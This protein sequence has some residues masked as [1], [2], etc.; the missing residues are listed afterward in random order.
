MNICITLKQ[1]AEKIIANR[2]LTLK[3]NIT[4][5]VAPGKHCPSSTVQLNNTANIFIKGLSDNGNKPEIS[6][7]QKSCFSLRISTL[8][9]IE[10]LLFAHSFSEVSNGGTI[11]VSGAEFVIIFQCAF[12]NNTI[13]KQGGAMRLQHIE[14]AY[15]LETQFINN[16]V[17]CRQTV[18]AGQL[19][20]HCIQRCTAFGGAVSIAYIKLLLIADSYFERN[21]AT[22][23][24]GMLVSVNSHI[25]LH[26]CT[27]IKSSTIDAPGLGGCLYIDVSSL[28]VVDSVFSENRGYFGGGIYSTSSMVDI[29]N[30][31]FLFN[32]ANLTGGG[33]HFDTYLTNSISNSYFKNNFAN[34]GGAAFIIHGDTFISRSTF[35]SNIGESKGGALYIDLHGQPSCT[36]S[37]DNKVIP[38]GNESVVSIVDSTFKQNKQKLMGGAIFAFRGV[39]NIT[40]CDFVENTGSNGGA[41]NANIIFL[42]IQ[43]NNFT[44]NT[45]GL[46]GAGLYFGN[47][48][49]YSSNN[50][51]KTNTGISGGALYSIF[52]TAVSQNDR[53]IAN[54]AYR[55]NG[56]AIHSFYADI[57]TTYCEFV[58]NYALLGGG[59]LFVG[60]GRYN[61]RKSLY[62]TNYSNRNGSALYISTS[63]V[64]MNGDTFL[65]NIG[66]QISSNSQAIFQLHNN[67]LNDDYSFTI[68]MTD[69]H[70]MCTNSTFINNVGS[71]YL[72]FSTLNFTSLLISV[73][74][75]GTTGGALTLVQSTAIFEHSS[76]VN[77][78]ENTALYGGGIFLSQSDLR[79]YTQCLNV[80]N[81]SA[82]K[83][84]GGIYG[85]Q[86]QITVRPI[87]TTDLTLFS[88]NNASLGGALFTVATS[89]FIFHGSTTF[90]SNHALRGGAAVLSEGSKIY[91]QKSAQDIYN[92]L[93][94]KLLFSNNSADYGGAIYVM[95]D[96]NSAV[97]CQQTARSNLRTLS[98]NE[99][100][101]QT[102]RLYYPNDT[103][104]NKYNYMNVFFQF[105][106][107][108]IAG[109]DI[110]GGL[111]DRCQI[112]AFSEIYNVG[113]RNELSGFDYLKTIAKFQ[114]NFDYSQITQIFDPQVVVTNITRNLVMNVISSD[115]VQLCFCENNTYNC[116][117]QLPRIFTRRGEAFSFR[118][119]TVDQVENPVNGTV[120]ATVV[121][122]GTRLKVGQARQVTAGECTELVYNIFSTEAEATF[123]VFPDGPCSDIGISFK[124][125]TTTFLP[126]KCPNGFQPAPLDNEC[127]CECDSF[128]S[129]YAS[130]CHL[131]SSTRVR[132]VRRSSKYWIQYVN[133]KNI[134]GFQFQDCPYDYCVSTPANLSISLPL[135]VDTQCAFN[136]SGIMCGDCE[137]GFS[138]VFGSSMCVQCSNNYLA[139]LIAFAA[140]GIAIVVLILILNVT[141]ATGTIH[142]I[143]LY[144]NIVAANSPAFLP[145]KT[146][147][148]IFLSW[149]NLDLG[150]ETC[151]YNGMDS[152]AKVLLQLVFPTYIIL[153]SILI[154]I[155]SNYW[156]WF[157]GLI[158]RKNP[159]ATLCTLFLLSY[160]KL[161]RTI[162]ECLQ[163]TH[164]TFPDGSTEILWFYNP[165]V[166][167]SSPSRIPFFMIAILIIALGTVY[168]ALLFFGQWLRKLPGKKLTRCI[169]S[170]KYNAF[171]DAYHAPFHFKHQF[172]LGVLLIVRII[173]HILSAVLEESTHLLVVSC[174]MCIVLVMK[175]LFKVYKNWLINLLETSFL[176]NLLLFASSSYYVSN[177]N[178]DQL[179][180]ANTSVSMAFVTFMGIVAYHCHTYFLTSFSVYQKLLLVVKSCRDVCKQKMS[181]VNTETAV[182]RNDTAHIRLLQR[183]PALDIIAPITAKDYVPPT[184]PSASKVPVPVKPVSS[185]TVVITK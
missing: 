185:T 87:E 86:S 38:T 76:Q 132:V 184:V 139:L 35:V 145:P 12:V 137:E 31:S 109:N 19:G 134:T 17:I 42:Y 143:I 37:C 7:K 41:I 100:F 77:I 160:S 130:F 29:Q 96:S 174:L 105:N 91:I 138:L 106:E 115:P 65:Y 69:S 166:L 53:Y 155:V 156:G 127:R 21:L 71:L 169:Q 108:N 6:C 114:I 43:R 183:E 182:A 70:G 60:N 128:V 33:V 23:F 168:T 148:R 67:T 152:H 73:G 22:C 49:L 90:L 163:F 162:I 153:L 82:K 103:E 25:S 20:A 16:S 111:L 80:D 136:R 81:N 117:S 141:V 78:S 161:L 10:N 147:L 48:T 4:L 13:R 24:G 55:S 83:F 180:L 144:A 140:A 172:W 64:N 173:H 149:L 75:V 116:S 159:V 102:L 2:S 151:F 8:I 158:G 125:V 171:I 66:G 57:T 126:C 32:S 58:G 84:G 26:N 157:A 36:V 68:Q 54:E 110:Y 154:I 164:L 3:A 123:K 61:S 122:S 133:N 113:F 15:I 62:T 150:I 39:L 63:L 118:A 52:S 104:F 50:M 107:G 167:Y 34:T 51:Y 89:L 97:L 177:T 56:G 170:N 9:H 47:G 74:N 27:C 59:A 181:T 94:I 142:G 79:V 40:N 85:Y 129:T 5:I 121:S 165:N 45:A 146:A 101:L 93:S 44:N 98:M 1:L 178:S 135:N 72:F 179:G 30:S 119:I 18:I 11:F 124:T 14:R 99:C 88:R 92:E 120:L 175:Q 176:I 46:F 112:N 131:E 28:D 95:D